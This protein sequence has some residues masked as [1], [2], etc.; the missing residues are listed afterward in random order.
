MA[1]KVHSDQQH[2]IGDWNNNLGYSLCS[3]LDV[4]VCSQQTAPPPSVTQWY[5]L[6]ELTLLCARCVYT[7]SLL[8]L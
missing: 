1:W 3:T 7:A 8:I 6:C 2:Q 4:D 5:C